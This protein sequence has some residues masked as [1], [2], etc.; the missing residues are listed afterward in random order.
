MKPGKS[1]RLVRALLRIRF[2]RFLS[3]ARSFWAAFL[4]DTTVF[5]VQAGV[6]SVLY[7]NTESLNGWNRWET[8]FFVGTFTLIDALF[9]ST[10]F[11]GVLRIPELIRTGE[12]DAYL[13]KPADSLLHVSFARA[14]PGSLLLGIPAL[15]LLSRAAAG[16]GW[17]FRLRDLLGYL[18]AV[19]L[20]LV[21]FFDLMILMRSAAF[22][23]GRIGGLQDLENSL[24]E[25]GFRVPGAVWRGGFRILFCVL[26]PYGLI[27]SF[28][29]EA[30]RGGL[31]AARWIGALG[32]VFCFSV[33][34]RLA[35]NRGLSRYSGTGS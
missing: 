2:T 5:L 8:L 13:C 35:W 21:L 7:L 26:L 12:L 22:R 17:V 27:A 16:M 10:F 32:I 33:L 9:M 6:F 1:F 28:P 11:F 3:E 18:A 24:V 4:V 25:T 23:W 34:A 31:G 30:F 20:M 15:L 29:T 14:D 19:C